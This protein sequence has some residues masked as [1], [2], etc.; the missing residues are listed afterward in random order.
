[1]KMEAWIW[2][3]LPREIWIER[4]PDIE[5]VYIKV[6]NHGG[7]SQFKISIFILYSKDINYIQVLSFLPLSY[8]SLA[9]P[10]V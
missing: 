6:K 10:G 9:L 1:M 3:E 4:I 5:T 8:P 7:P 2:K